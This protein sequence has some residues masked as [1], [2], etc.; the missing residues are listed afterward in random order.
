MFDSRVSYDGSSGGGE[1][2]GVN[3]AP[4]P[5]AGGLVPGC[6]VARDAPCD[7]DTAVPNGDI[8]RAR[9][10]CHVCVSSQWCRTSSAACGGISVLKHS[11]T[12]RWDISPYQRAGLQFK[13]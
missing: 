3:P 1:G 13:G 8:A 9:G 10:E 11:N 12:V 4:S 6:W 5:G 7:A 2:C